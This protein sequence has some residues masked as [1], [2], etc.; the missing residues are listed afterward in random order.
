MTNFLLQLYLLGL[1]AVVL[2]RFDFLNINYYLY[3]LVSIFF[4]K[5]I[6]LYLD[7]ILRSLS[8]IMS[9]FSEWFNKSMGI[10][11]LGVFLP[12]Q[13]VKT[14]MF[15]VFEKFASNKAICVIISLGSYLWLFWNFQ[16]SCEFTSETVNNVIQNIPGVSDK[17]IKELIPTL[18]GALSIAASLSLT[19]YY[20]TYKEQKA[21]AESSVNQQSVNSILL[22]FI[23]TVAQTVIYLTRLG[24]YWTPPQGNEVVFIT[25]NFDYIATAAL[26]FC[27]SIFTGLLMVDSLIDGMNIK[28]LLRR[29]IRA[30]ENIVFSLSFIPSWWIFNI[31]RKYLYGKLHCLIES[32]YQMLV[33]TV[34]KNMSEVF[35][36]NSKLW[37]ET[38]LRCHTEN[39]LFSLL[40]TERYLY[41]LEVDSEDYLK[42]Y[43]SL[44]KNH[45]ALIFCL[46]NKQK[47]QEARDCIT[48]YFM[49]SPKGVKFNDVGSDKIYEK[50]Y[51][52]MVT[53]YFTV[54]YELA[55]YL[56]KN[57]HI[58][59][60]PVI[61]NI[62]QM[63]LRY[64]PREE[65]LLF[66]K[67]LII[68]AVEKND[69]R[70][71]SLLAHCL[72]STINSEDDLENIAT[73]D[74]EIKDCL[75]N[76]YG[77]ITCE[78]K[79]N[80][81]QDAE[82]NNTEKK[83]EDKSLEIGKCLYVFLQAALKSIELSHYSTTGFLVKYLISYFKSDIFN[84]VYSNFIEKGAIKDPLFEKAALNNEII[85]S[86]S[87][88]EQ[89]A[90]YC[91]AKL[92]ILIY[93]QQRYIKSKNIT[94]KHVPEKYI[95][96]VLLKNIGYLEYLFKK[97]ENSKGKYD[98]LCLN[99]EKFLSSI[100]NTLFSINNE[101]NA[102]KDDMSESIKRVRLGV[103][104]NI[105]YLLERKN[106]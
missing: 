10:I 67:A 102:V 30:I 98:L 105:Q 62:K 87:F 93:I 55:V 40:P 68:K 12:I 41:L 14:I 71:L 90:K 26:L 29:N 66:F 81:G 36:E 7:K 82:N 51:K 78:L 47:M 95:D 74:Q 99:D 17:K 106:L 101:N 48:A 37:I 24:L 94:V 9:Q 63:A 53:V 80:Y 4:V 34:E 23:L 91:I 64:A 54:L 22:V 75:L 21:T 88:N 19:F 15:Y 5:L 39:R 69:T 16:I 32:V 65:L 35:Y 56:N 38:A 49:L 76:G 96:F 1:F 83:E 6:C 58:G 28:S 13:T 100:K 11:L 43:K 33:L 86:F 61:I 104:R 50:N 52:K 57:D 44:L 84:K 3:V 70:L 92:T 97:L 27:S 45:L 46:Y 20:F 73:V 42:L 89:T 8:P 18:V 59:L 25:E 31:F 60:H 2:K 85:A 77:E 72:I 79:I 103:L